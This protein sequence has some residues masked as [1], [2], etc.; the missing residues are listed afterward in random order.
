MRQLNGLSE[1]EV[2]RVGR[3]HVFSAQVTQR[4]GVNV[5]EEMLAGTQE[6]R[7]DGDVQL[8]NE[9]RFEVLPDRRHSTAE[10]NI[11]TIGGVTGPLQCRVDSFCDEMESRAAL[12]GD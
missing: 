1:H 2:R 8:I 6:D 9:P 10:P 7:A 5:G 4:R 3:R 12:H 11:P